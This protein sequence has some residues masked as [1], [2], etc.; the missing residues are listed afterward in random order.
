MREYGDFQ[1]NAKSNFFSTNEDEFSEDWFGTDQSCCFC[2]PI[3]SGVKM[4]GPYW[5]FNFVFLALQIHG[6]TDDGSSTHEMASPQ[7]YYV[8]YTIILPL[9]YSFYRYARWL[10]SD[11]SD[12]RN[13]LVTAGLISVLSVGSLYIWFFI[14]FSNLEATDFLTEDKILL[15]LLLFAVP[16]LSINSYLYSKLKVFANQLEDQKEKKQIIIQKIKNQGKK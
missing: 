8:S 16:Q 5:I 1:L 4:V 3:Q 7:F 10:C 9:L 6:I 15:I 14:Y 2:A 12:Q 13:S 11:S